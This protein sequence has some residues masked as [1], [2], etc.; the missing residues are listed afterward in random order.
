MVQVPASCLVC[1]FLALAPIGTDIKANPWIVAVNQVGKVK[2]GSRET[3]VAGTFDVCVVGGGCT[4]VFAAVRAARMGASVALVERAGLF[5]GTATAG[6]ANVWH[7]IHDVEGKRQIIGGLTWEVIERLRARGTLA[8]RGEPGREVYVF[9]P[10]ELATELD[11]L[12]LE[13]GVCPFLHSHF[14]SPVAERGR[15]SAIAIED[16]SGRRAIKAQNYVDATGDGCLVGRMGLPLRRRRAMQPPT[17]CFLLQGL[18]EIRKGDPEF[19]LADVVFDQ[20]NPNALEPGFLWL[21]S[22]PG[23]SDISM[24]AGTRVFGADCG[25]PDELTR[26]EIEGR[27]QVRRICDTLRSGHLP[28][29]RDPLVA[30]ACSIGVRESRHPRCLH[31]LKEREV[32]RGTSFPDAIANGTYRVDIHNPNGPGVVFR[33]LDGREERVSPGEVTAS[34]WLPEGEATASFYQIPYR[35]LV[36]TGSQNVLVAGRLVDADRGAYGAIRVMVNCN[37]TGEAAGTASCIALKQEISVGDIDGDQLR[38]E[39]KRHGSIVL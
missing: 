20:G 8:C 32:L 4:G 23:L 26:A 30:L 38:G 16:A 7:S 29:G 2:E 3:P 35:S 39:M 18:D 6:L 15:L 19:S 13:S 14:A 27:R 37:Q 10:A 36:P 31:T 21:S 17:T 24:V 28:P 11:S 33:Y 1:R 34:R 12:V 5:G 22:V 25:D 9:H